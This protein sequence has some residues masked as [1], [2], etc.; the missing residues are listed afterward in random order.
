MFSL[1]KAFL[2]WSNDHFEIN[3]CAW[4]LIDK[5]PK[6]IINI[7]KSWMKLTYIKDSK[8]LEKKYIEI[9]KGNLDPTKGYLVR[10]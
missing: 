6:L 3:S 1:T 10:L 8:A 4:I 2:N 9:L 7:I 5:N